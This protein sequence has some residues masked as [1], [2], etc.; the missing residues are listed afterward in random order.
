MNED[1]FNET[2]AELGGALFPKESSSN[3]GFDA[4]VGQQTPAS[5][6]VPEASGASAQSTPEGNGSPAPTQQAPAQ[7]PA[8]Q[9]VAGP[10]APGQQPTSQPPLP[11][12]QDPNIAPN[13]WRAE[14]KAQWATLPQSVREEI[15]KR[16]GDFA[17]GLQQFRQQAQGFESFR[18]VAA[19]Y[20]A[21]MQRAGIDPIR[22][23]GELFAVHH[24]LISG[25]PADRIDILQNLARQFGVNLEHL[26]PNNTPYESPEAKL[27]REQNR[28]L[29]NQI[30]QQR[31]YQVR[32]VQHSLSSELDAFESD[33]ANVHFQ[34]VGNEMATLIQS[35]QAANLKEAYDKAC[36]LNP[37]V[38]AILLQQQQASQNQQAQQ[39]ARARAAQA[40]TRMNGA[41]PTLPAAPQQLQGGQK[42]MAQ[43]MES[44]L[45]ELLARGQ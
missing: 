24:R 12:S 13:T 44:T 29:Q 28:V 40:A 21:D 17:R 5:A 16:E 32:Q 42:T 9:P 14:A 35:G 22:H 3:P 15:R 10:A 6:T 30:Q 25:T 45:D 41:S 36:W 7:Q 18:Q 4:D 11:P 8:G 38:R 31:A 33:P 37:E 19:P 1:E 39:Q 26:D 27:L 23:A 34:K 20:V 43:T 2:A